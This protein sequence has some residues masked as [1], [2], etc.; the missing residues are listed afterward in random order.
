ME[1]DF[2]YI[3]DIVEGGVRVN[4][5]IAQ[6][7]PDWSPAHPAPGSS[8]AP[9]RIYNIGNNHPV[10]LL[11]MVEILEHELGQKARRDFKPMPP[12][13]VA[14]TFAD[15]DAH[16][17]ADDFA[18][19]PPQDTGHPPSHTWHTPSHKPQPG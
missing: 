8:S 15:I 6:P 17:D 13:A 7:N 10:Q 11:R 2:T 1:R 14:R 3:D 16:I 9:F 5:R 12:G 18:S 4:D 19:I